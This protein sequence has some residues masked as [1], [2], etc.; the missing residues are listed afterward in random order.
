MLSR[1]G[2]R[3]DKRKRVICESDDEEE[4]AESV[5]A[6]ELACLVPTLATARAPTPDTLGAVGVVAAVTVDVADAAASSAAG[7]AANAAGD[8]AD[9]A[10]SVT[11]P[12]THT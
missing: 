3:V 5:V 2:Y 1:G 7:A 8:A 6:P 11:P 9:V 12:T 4:S 10:G